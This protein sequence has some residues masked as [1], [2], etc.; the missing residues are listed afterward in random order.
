MIDNP[1]SQEERGLVQRL[2]KQE[3]DAREQAATAQS[4]EH[5]PD[6]AHRRVGQGALH[7]ALY[8]R[9]C[10][11]QQCCDDAHPGDERECHR[12]SRQ[13]ER[14]EPRHEKDAGGHHGGRVQEG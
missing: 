3:Q 8:Q 13:E 1:G 2:R 5:Q 14:V 9:C 12:A 10:S 6:L 7:I 4:Y 11:T